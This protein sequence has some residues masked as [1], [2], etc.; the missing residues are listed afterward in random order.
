MIIFSYTFNQVVE[1][2]RQKKLSYSQGTQVVY[3]P[4]HISKSGGRYQIYHINAGYMSAAD[5]YGCRVC[6]RGFTTM[7]GLRAH[8]ASDAH[9]AETAKIVANSVSWLNLEDLL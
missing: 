7:H 6:G 5:F 3:K 8:Q 1:F 4:L 2:S 9:L